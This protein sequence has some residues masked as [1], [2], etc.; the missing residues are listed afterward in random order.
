A[1]DLSLFVVIFLVVI[2]CGIVFK[3]TYNFAICA[4]FFILG[5]ANVFLQCVNDFKVSE[6]A[7]YSP[8]SAAKLILTQNSITK[9]DKQKAEAEVVALYSNGTWK[10][11]HGK[12]LIYISGLPDSTLP[13]GTTLIV[14]ARFDSIRNFTPD[15]DYKTFLARKQ[16]HTQ[17]FV[18]SSKVIYGEQQTHGTLQMFAQKINT[19]CEKAL[20]KYLHSEREFSVV[21]AMLLGNQAGMDE[22]TAMSYRSTGAV[23]ILSVSGMHLGVFAFILLHIF[24]FL[25]RKKWKLW[26]RFFIVCSFI[27][28][29]AL[30][31]GMSASV[32]RA[33]TMFSFVAL[34]QCLDRNISIYR[35][36]MLS[37]FLLLTINPLLIY[38]VGLQL[39]YAAVLGIAAI[40]PQLQKLWKIKTSATSKTTGAKNNT[41]VLKPLYKS[42]KFLY[43]L[44]SISISAQL[45]T[46]PFILYYFKQFP[47]YFLPSNFIASPLSS[48]ILPAGMLVCLLHFLFEPLATFAGFL[49]EKIC[50]MLNSTLAWIAGLPY[51]VYAISMSVAGGIM[52]YAAI[53]FFLFA[54]KKRNKYAFHLSLVSLW[55]CV[56]F[57]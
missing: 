46:L 25:K 11:T 22:E 20:Q 18:H 8:A 48:I 17:I 56:L 41:L 57:T 1:L 45:L 4:L 55:L 5:Y 14:P 12:T 31:T 34:G 28:L 26:L 10:K 43:D 51:A 36:L 6:D 44:S 19:S 23:H 9:K 35:S 52:L 49:L 37:A 24:S 29:Y 33:A 30:I 40:H 47:I 42:G 2:L 16:I 15:F 7:I 50:L 54:Y 39:S 32:I 21:N 53:L 13:L 27:W 38:N 3:N